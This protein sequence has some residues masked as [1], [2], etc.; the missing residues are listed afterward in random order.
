LCSIWGSDG[1][2]QLKQVLLKLLFLPTE[3]LSLPSITK[4]NLSSLC[5]V[6]SE[7]CEIELDPRIF[8]RDKYLKPEINFHFPKLFVLIGVTE[9]IG[10]IFFIFIKN[11]IID[12]D[13]W[14][15]SMILSIGSGICN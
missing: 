10:E 8:Y 4:P 13:S 3:I 2:R 14:I 12:F 6:S 5:P 9:Y 15:K 1:L 11:D 7:L